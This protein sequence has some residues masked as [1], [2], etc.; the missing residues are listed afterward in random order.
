MNNARKIRLLRFISW[1]IVH[2]FD[3]THTEKAQIKCIDIIVGD[4]SDDLKKKN[5]T[6]NF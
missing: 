2:S 1:V 5:E 4:M 6:E 3:H